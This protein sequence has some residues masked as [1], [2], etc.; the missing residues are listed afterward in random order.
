MFEDLSGVFAAAITPL[1]ADFTIDYAGIPPLLEFLASRGCH[2]ALLFGTTGEGPSFAASERRQAWQ[3]ALDWRRTNQ[4]FRLLGGTGTPSLSETVELTRTAFELGLDGVVTLP[5]YYFRKVND[6]GLFAWFSQ[7]IEQAVPTG[8]AFFG[9]HFPNVSG[10]PLSLELLA[11]LKETFPE[12]FTGIKDSSGEVD[13]ARQLGRR[14]GAELCVLTGN[15]SLLSLALDNH[16]AGCITAMANLYS[17]DARLVWDS[18]RSGDRAAQ[19]A[20]QQRLAAVRAV[21]ER[22]PPFP[23]LLKALLAR[24]HGFPLWTVRPPLLPLPVEL[25]GQVEQELAKL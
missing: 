11:R 1:Q 20:A 24:G 9:Y 5:P 10:V 6:A 17:Q 22:Y 23:P 7:V 13:F 3:V 16:A 19:Q 14:F 8:K 2:G 12:R 21:M 18:Y 25:A 15:D 4:A